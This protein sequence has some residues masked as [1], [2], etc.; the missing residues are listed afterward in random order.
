[1]TLGEKIKR[2]R[3][4]NGLTQEELAKKLFVSRQTIT[5]WE[6]NRTKPDLRIIAEL[7]K[8]F[9]LD[10]NYFL[11]E[12]IINEEENNIEKLKKPN[13]KKKNN[14]VYYIG[15]IT[16]A[17]IL[18]T[19][20]TIAILVNDQINKDRALYF[21]RKGTYMSFDEELLIDSLSSLREYNIPYYIEADGIDYYNLLYK[22]GFTST[23]Y[24]PIDAYTSCYCYSIYYNKYTDTY[25]S[26]LDTILNSDKQYAHYSFEGYMVN[27][28]LKTPNINLE[29]AS[30]DK[31]GNIIKQDKFV[32]CYN[33]IINDRGELEDDYLDSYYVEGAKLYHIR[34]SNGDSSATYNIDKT[35]EIF[36]NLALSDS[37]LDKLLMTKF[38]ID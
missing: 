10:I 3:K 7:G 34:L 6:C 38:I 25:K 1:M 35:T 26:E 12:N 22:E 24:I 17:I 31:D 20:I 16:L 27:Y 2:L 36:T 18:I 37:K 19:A 9:S 5:S 23:G 8:I 32:P 29:I 28:C 33:G 13:N 11:D 21:E 15:G 30:Y 14:L 4:D